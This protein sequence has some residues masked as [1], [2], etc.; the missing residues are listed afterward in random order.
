M[1][2]SYFDTENKNYKPKETAL[3]TGCRAMN[4]DVGG[5]QNMFYFCLNLKVLTK[6]KGGGGFG[7][8]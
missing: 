2:R 4:S 1:I 3:K 5:E 8:E 7:P 6:K